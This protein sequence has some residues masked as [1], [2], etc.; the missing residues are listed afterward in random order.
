MTEQHFDQQ[1]RK[2]LENLTPPYDPLSW[3]SLE[4]R[5]DSQMA[6][7][8]SDAADP[9]AWDAAARQK[10]AALKVPYE[11]ESWQ[12]LTAKMHLRAQRQR[13]VL[14]MKLIEIA[15]ILV[16]IWSLR[17]SNVFEGKPPTPE[18]CPK[19]SAT[20]LARHV[21]PLASPFQAS[22]PIS[23][24]KRACVKLQPS[25]MSAE[26]SSAQPLDNSDTVTQDLL[27]TYRASETALALPQST[28]LPS[29]LQPVLAPLPTCSINLLPTFQIPA[30]TNKRK[31]TRAQSSLF[32][33]AGAAVHYHQIQLPTQTLMVHSYGLACRAE[34]R[35]HRW[36]WNAGIE[37]TSLAFT[38]HAREYVYSGTPQTGYY[39]IKLSQVRTDM[40]LLPV[41]VLRQLFKRERAQLWAIGG[42]TGHLA[43]FKAY[44]YD[45][46]YY[47]PGHLPI[48]QLDPST[49]SHQTQRGRGL[50]EGGNRSSN[51]YLSADLG[52]R[53]EYEWL[54]G[55]YSLYIAPIYRRGVTP[56][57]DAQG[58]RQHTWVLQVGVRIAP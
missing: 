16:F 54:E 47:P 5:L 40:L 3:Q 53:G 38:P 42:L 22:A 24:K 36:A 43:L 31:S 17:V 49:K 44:D 9:T 57:P 25:G 13:F 33:F 27:Q 34:R 1:L 30:E 12:L 35:R 10:I 6:T 50:L 28:L 52:L 37:Y 56:A 51:I 7:G 29:L 48:K 2:V 58:G 55:K 20:P 41:G 11:P 8:D 14:G 23:S 46:N 4:R 21:A 32:L 19:P 15:A 45:Y 39:S 18:Q 26:F